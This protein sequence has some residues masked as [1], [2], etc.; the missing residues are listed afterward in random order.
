MLGFVG[1]TSID[2]SV[3]E[4][5]V[6]VVDAETAPRLAEIIV[7]PGAVVVVTPFEPGVLLIEATV[8]TEEAHVTEAEMSCTELSV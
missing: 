4:F 7:E 3:A 1:V 2:S 5:T 8:L 6:R